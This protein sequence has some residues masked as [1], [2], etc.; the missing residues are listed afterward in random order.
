M[1]EGPW[2]LEWRIYYSRYQG[3]NAANFYT[4]SSADG[5]WE[6]APRDGVLTVLTMAP[7]HNWTRFMIQDH[8][9]YY[10]VPGRG[11]MFSESDELIRVHV[12]AILAS[13]IKRGGNAF[14]ED[15][16]KVIDAAAHDVDFP[17][18]KP[19][20]RTSDWPAR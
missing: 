1:Q 14:R 17:R 2:L 9:R 8:E 3:P 4:F 5:P 6:E 12:P 19:R 20:R 13:Q 16:V 10:K 11:V 18:G 15:W 7:S